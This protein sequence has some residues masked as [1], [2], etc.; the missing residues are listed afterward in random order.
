M[1]A[2]DSSAWA[3]KAAEAIRLLGLTNNQVYD[4]QSHPQPLIAALG[5]KRP[6]MQI[7]SA[8]A[9]AMLPRPRRS[10]QSALAVK[11]DADAKV[12]IAA[13]DALRESLKKFGNQT[14]DE[15][16]QA[17]VEVV[18]DSTASP[19]LR[20]AAAAALG[21]MNLPSEKIKS[22]IRTFTPSKAFNRKEHRRR[23]NGCAAALFACSRLAPQLTISYLSRGSQSGRA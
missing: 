16:S 23:A 2:E 12:R 18:N 3:V 11:A 6:E 19:E 20:N 22:L 10:R 21:A 4:R 8:G 17:V 5:D 15:Q 1:A 13:F 14:T 9:L 7:A